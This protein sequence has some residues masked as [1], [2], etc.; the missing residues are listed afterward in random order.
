MK[1]AT[2]NLL[3]ANPFLGSGAGNPLTDDSDFTLVSKGEE[4]EPDRSYHCE[5]IN[6]C[7]CYDNRLKTVLRTAQKLSITEYRDNYQHVE[8]A[9][10]AAL[11]APRLQVMPRN[12]QS[13]GAVAQ[14][15]LLQY[16]AINPL[17][18]LHRSFPNAKTARLNSL[19]KV[20]FG[21]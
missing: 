6:P 5:I 7:G 21:E 13:F 11:K 16:D 10:V 4:I 9:Q 8:A 12:N 20:I 19:K 17:R 3:A 14:R 2:S 18:L 15:S 1:L